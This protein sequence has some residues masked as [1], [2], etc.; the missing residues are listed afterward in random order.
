MKIDASGVF[1]VADVL[2]AELKSKDV[3]A[4]LAFE[5]AD[6]CDTEFGSFVGQAKETS[7]DAVELK[8]VAYPVHTKRDSFTYLVSTSRLLMQVGF[9]LTRGQKSVELLVNLT[10]HRQSTPGQSQDGCDEGSSTG[11]ACSSSTSDAATEGF[12]RFS[13]ITSQG[14]LQNTARPDLHT[15]ACGAASMKTCYS[16]QEAIHQFKVVMVAIAE[17]LM[18]EVVPVEFPEESPASCPS[19]YHSLSSPSDE[20]LEALENVLTPLQSLL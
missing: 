19:E 14:H 18:D 7:S 10:G 9:T 16:L 13:I 4:S 3:G 12:S 17:H 1:E 2:L 5:V 6:T 11:D 20:Y 8:F 15:A